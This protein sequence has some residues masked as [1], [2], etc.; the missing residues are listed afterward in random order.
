MII[1]DNSIYTV[2]VQAVLYSY[3]GELSA[4]P[5]QQTRTQR[6]HPR[7]MFGGIQVIAIDRAIYFC[8]VAFDDTTSEREKTWLFRT[9][10]EL[11]LIH[12]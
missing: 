4:F 7:F 12:I 1:S 9:D 11:S 10:E 6:T 2:V 8:R 3:M 5:P